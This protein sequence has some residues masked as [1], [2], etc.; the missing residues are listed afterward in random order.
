MVDKIVANMSG[1][2]QQIE[3]RADLQHNIKVH[4][5]SYDRQLISFTDSNVEIAKRITNLD[6][7]ER[8]T[9]RDTSDYDVVMGLEDGYWKIF[10]LLKINTNE[11]I[12]TT[13][14]KLNKIP[15]PS[16]IKGVNYYPS[17]HP[18]LDFWKNYNPETTIKDLE[19]VNE[20]QLN[21]IRF[22]IPYALFGKGSLDQKLLAQ[23]DHF[24]D[25]CQEQ[26]I[27]TS[28][29]LFDFPESY[30]LD[31]YPA[32]RKHLMQLLERYHDHPAIALWDLK[33]EPDL[34]FKNYEADIVL[35]WLSF[36]IDTAKEQAPN[37]NLTI[38]WSDAAYAHLFAD[39]LDLISYHIYK[40][41][42]E[43]KKH[44]RKLKKEHIKDK[45]IYISEFGKS[46]YRSK[47]IP[48][49]STEKEQ[50]HYTKEVLQLMTEEEIPHYAFWTLH[51]FTKGPK[52]I[53]GR[54][55]WIINTQ[56]NMGIVN[57]E[58]DK[59]LVANNFIGQKEKVE[60]LAWYEKIQPFY[61]IAGLIL[62]LAFLLYNKS[63]I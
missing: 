32:T 11:R 30:D 3:E 25:T 8:L 56:K 17:E 34:D 43:E 21:H 47:V 27:S 63:D 49:G 46:S 44:L 20:L 38:G 9:F 5:F 33:N 4:L 15:L 42:E 35:D 57:T 6:T 28:I 62:L 40:E 12:N 45:A 51:D 60:S 52:E 48:F 1:E 2:S 53:L 37:I 18:W 23:L 55:P 14:R 59:K 36:M 50:A 16:N 29:T 39:K 19:L 24:L 13:D 41:I 58:G 31:F 7:K 61:F 26:E 10:E 22:F 54:K